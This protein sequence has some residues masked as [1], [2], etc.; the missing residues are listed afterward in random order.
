M[1]ESH[2]WSTH[3]NEYSFD[4][5]DLPFTCDPDLEGNYIHCKQVGL[6]EQ[7]TPIYIGEGLL[8]ERVNDD[9]HLTCALEKGATHVHI[10]LEE[11][12]LSRTFV[13]RD[14]LLAH[15]EAYTPIGCNVK[16]GG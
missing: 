6:L 9:E 4:I 2:V 12:L 10:R 14:L 11:G 15:S 1:P 16:E 7:W 3:D 8:N 5:Y 13:E